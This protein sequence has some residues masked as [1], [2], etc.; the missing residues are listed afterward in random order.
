MKD[1]VSNSAELAACLTGVG[2]IGPSCKISLKEIE[3]I[4]FC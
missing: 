1:G 4:C 3:E 2:I